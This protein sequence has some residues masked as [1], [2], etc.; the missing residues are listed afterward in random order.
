MNDVRPRRKS[1]FGGLLWIILG[2]LLLANNL[3][4][5]FGFWELLGNWWPLILILLGLGK[6]FEHYAATR[7]GDAP[8]R[9]LSGGE[10]F[11]LILLFL[12]AGAYSGFVRFG[13]EADLD[14]DLPWWNS[15]SYTEEVVAKNVKPNS[16][17]RVNVN[18][19]DL[20]VIP[21]D[22]NE[23]R[24]VVN[25][26]IRAID[27]TE[28][29]S[30]TNDYGVTIQESG[31]T[32][33]VQPK[34]GIAVH[35]DNEESRRSP[36]LARRVRL[37]LEIRVPKQSVLNLRTDRGGVRV[38]GVAG[39]VT[40]SSRSGDIEIRDVTG[41]VEVDMRGGDLR[42]ANAKGDVKVTGRGGEVDVSDIT[43]FATVNGEYGG[44]V[45]MKNVAKE[46]RYNSRRTDLTLS[47]LKGSMELNSGDMEIVDAG[48][49]NINTSSYDIKMEN[50]MGRIVVDNK[51]GEVDLRFATPPKEDIEVNNERADVHVT[52][53]EKSEFTVDASSRRGPAESD[54][55]DGI[56]TSQDREDGKIEGKVGARGPNIKL[57]TTHGTVA[58][59]KGN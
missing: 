5:R 52:L 36:R 12:F 56:R 9:L 41:N 38:N 32:Y 26:T 47:L 10:V 20:N 46:A 1:I 13:R 57:R 33:E 48:N 24:V 15:Y 28:G 45:R 58:L 54:F 18:R 35:M 25:K 53:P 16:T 7:S 43:G 14:I 59:R 34:G 23:I 29:R 37:D 6:L 51:N 19:G 31:G 22:G 30:L 2:G 11:L 49:A 55:K 21:I 8:A 3:G 27:D 42:V 17:I 50:V 40:T 4:A 39:N 44:P